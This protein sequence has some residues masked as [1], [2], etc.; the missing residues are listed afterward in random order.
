[1]TAPGDRQPT[2]GWI[3]RWRG[4]DGPLAPKV[5]A[6]GIAAGVFAAMFAFVRIEVVPPPGWIENKARVIQLD[7]GPES[8]LWRTRALEGGP[9]PPRY[10]PQAWLGM[11]AFEEMLL[12]AGRVEAPP[13]EP[14][15]RKLQLEATPGPVP[16]RARGERVFPER[17]P[18]RPAAVTAE[19]SP[20]APSLEP[21]AGLAADAL[22][23][24][25]P[26]LDALPPDDTARRW[27]FL[28]RLG[29]GGSV[30][31]AVCVSH[32]GQP[33]AAI[34]ETWFRSIR[35]PDSAPEGWVAVGLTF[36]RTA[37]DDDSDAR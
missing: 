14:E 16:L 35:F 32:P 21:L 7:D 23:T 10:E 34:L 28:L 36:V 33:A 3:F 37:P 18:S 6:V 12:D 8:R 22:P 15:L 5:A 26:P 17:R 20:L 4:L 31:E 29:P 19:T 1:M 2:N 11:P 25:L 27:R 13:Y 24:E 9:F 30:T